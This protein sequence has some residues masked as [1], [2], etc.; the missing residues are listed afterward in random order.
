MSRAVLQELRSHHAFDPTPRFHDLGVYHVPFDSMHGTNRVEHRLRQ[1]ALNGERIALIAE[2]GCGKSSVISH[3]LG[4][5]SEQVAPILVPVHG[6][7]RE[8]ARAQCV[9]DAILLE[10]NRQ[11]ERAGR[12]PASTARVM[13]DRRSVTRQDNHERGAGVSLLGWLNAKIANQI[14]EQTT[15]TEANSLAAKV[16]VI[17][18]CLAPIHA[19]GLMPVVVFDDTDRWIG[20]T[21]AA[22]ALG[23]FGNAIRWLSDLP[24]SVIVATHRNYLESSA[25]DEAHLTYLDT[26]VDI[27]RVPSIDELTRV[28]QKRVEAHTGNAQNVKD[29]ARPGDAIDESAV[30]RLFDLYEAGVP[31]RRVIQVAHIAVVEAVDSNSEVVTDHHIRAARHA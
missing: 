14:V 22:I 15:T 9:A 18:Q 8:A 31:L 1:G 26:R 2:S 12:S 11:A 19:D 10:L 3:V 21:D 7:E 28:L 4:P 5:T 16:E 13:G 29:P 23:F 25:Q 30:A 27:P 20:D 17:H 24:V 6:L